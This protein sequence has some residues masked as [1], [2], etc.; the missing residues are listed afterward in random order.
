[1]KALF[2]FANF[3]R[4]EDTELLGELTM[5]NMSSWENQPPTLIFPLLKQH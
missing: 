2:V 4:L 3:D 5:E 1:M